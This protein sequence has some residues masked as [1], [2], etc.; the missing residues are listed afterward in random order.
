MEDSPVASYIESNDISKLYNY[1]FEALES[2][3]SVYIDKAV[4]FLLTTSF[5][6]EMIFYESLPDILT[7]MQEPMI[8]IDRLNE[9][10][11][12]NSKISFYAAYSLYLLMTNFDIDVPNFHKNFYELIQKDNVTTHRVK[13]LSFI[14]LILYTDDLSLKIVKAYI[15]TLCRI[16]VN[17]ESYICIEILNLVFVLMKLHPMC[18]EMCNEAGYILDSDK[19]TE[20]LDTI[21]YDNFQTYLFELDILSS[22]IQPVRKIVNLIRN[23][24]Y[25][26]KEKYD[27]RLLIEQEINVD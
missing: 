11:C 16:A 9:V 10:F 2:D 12:Q 24:S 4:Q 23:E 5:N 19:V 7:K 21:S 26:K 14:K 25:K 20:C 8:I 22:G 13:F 15:K 18:F 27:R 17:I 3:K 1:V 6:E